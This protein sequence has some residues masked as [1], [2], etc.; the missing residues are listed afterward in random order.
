MCHQ[1]NKILEQETGVTEGDENQD[2]TP[3][4][5]FKFIINPK[6]FAQSVE[7]MFYLSFLI[8]DGLCAL[9]YDKN[10]DEPMICMPHPSSIPGSTE[11]NGMLK[12]LAPSLRQ[13]I[14]QMVSDDNRSC[15]S[16]T[17]L[18]GRLVPRQ[19]GTMNS[20]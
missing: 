6:D 3:I 9:E 4:N 10:T 16:S 15:L 11:T 13:R 7:N 8:R 19:I 14:A 2:P 17:W 12:G 20:R 5:L 1:L 18:H